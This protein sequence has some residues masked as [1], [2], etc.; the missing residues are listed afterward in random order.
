MILHMVTRLGQLNTQRGLATYGY[1][2]AMWS[3]G[4]IYIHV[5]I[6]Q[7]GGRI[8]QFTSNIQMAIHIIAKEQDHNKS[9]MLKR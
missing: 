9:R 5:Q 7:G 8:K 2:T 6:T 1:P 3:A 4:P